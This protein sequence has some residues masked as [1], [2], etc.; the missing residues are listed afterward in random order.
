[1]N[2]VILG[3]AHPLRSGGITSFNE[4]VALELQQEGH[5]VEICSFS[6]Q[7]PSFLF[8][9]KSQFTTDPAPEDLRIN[10][11]INSI[12]PFN[13]IRVGYRL[14]QKKPDI[15]IV[16]FWLPFM[17]PCL[18]T[19]L[20]IVKRNR[21]TIVI[22]IAD[23][24]LPHE[25]RIGDKSF[26]KYFVQPVDGF[27]SM[28]KN[29]LKD[30]SLYS[31]KIA[32]HTPHPLYDS[33]G[34]S[35]SRTEARKKLNINPDKKVL[36]FFGFVR[37]YKGLDILLEAMTD[38]RVK[39]EKIELIIAG[40]F[41]DNYSEYFS[42][43]E[44]FGIKDRIHLYSEFVPN[45]KVS[46]FFSA[47]DAVVLPYR[48]GTQSGVTQLSFHFRKPVIVTN[49][50]GIGEVVRHGKTG[51]ITEPK[52]KSIADTIMKFYDEFPNIAFEENI[53]KENANY[54]WKSFTQSIFETAE[55]IRS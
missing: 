51:F 40:E 54:D 53:L 48:Q 19:I 30:I 29:V 18:G 43:I 21:H 41:Y 49:V 32:R 20:R 28:S 11:I 5:N 27:I 38:E 25:K 4:R 47:A 36:L 23:N 44:A 10:A 37:K 16:R 42:K 24:I 22:C 7:Y 6:L 9:G 8:P 15:I 46:C 34:Q 33:Y 1:M 45:N 52:I 13:W 12:N 2:I 35:L 14:C 31:N 50:G 55:S 26:T 39:R 17:G 3:S